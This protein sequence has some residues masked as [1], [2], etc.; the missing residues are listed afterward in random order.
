ML[1]GYADIMRIMV[2]VANSWRTTGD[3]SAGWDSMLRCLDN[4]VGLSE[5]AG[6]GAWNDPDML[7]VWKIPSAGPLPN[8]AFNQNSVMTGST[9]VS[10]MCCEKLAEVMLGQGTQLA[11]LL[12]L[13]CVNCMRPGKS[14]A[15]GRPAGMFCGKLSCLVQH[16]ETSPGIC[17]KL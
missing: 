15:K 2:Q 8:N 16:I 4:T 12:G 1:H 14:T 6:P 3:I 13:A 11:G 17:I 9:A 5:F 10:V 7:E